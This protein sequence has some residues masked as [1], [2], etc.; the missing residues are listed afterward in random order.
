LEF[1]TNQK[2]SIFLVDFNRNNYV[3]FLSIVPLD[4]DT[5]RYLL[6]DYLQ[7][8]DFLNLDVTSTVAQ[9]LK[10]SK[11]LH[12]MET[13][14]DLQKAVSTSIGIPRDTQEI[15][16]NRLTVKSWLVLIYTIKHRFSQIHQ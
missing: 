16:S 5:A 13:L 1:K 14:S 9:M 12:G 10:V 11:Q 2:L 6:K 8:Q 3:E 4:T 15:I 7:P